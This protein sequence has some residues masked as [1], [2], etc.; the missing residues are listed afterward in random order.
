LRQAVKR[1]GGGVTIQNSIDS[2]TWGGSWAIKQEQAEAIAPCILWLDEL[3]K[4][5][6][7]VGFLTWM[8]EKNL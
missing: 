2:W 5:F 6:A 4:A 3:E 8:H 1:K 7:G